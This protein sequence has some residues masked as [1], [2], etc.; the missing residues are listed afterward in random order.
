MNQYNLFLNNSSFFMINLYNHGLTK[1]NFVNKKIM[2]KK[3]GPGSISKDFNMTYV[4]VT[5]LLTK[6]YSI[7]LICKERD[8]GTSRTYY[9]LNDD[10]VNVAERLLNLNKLISIS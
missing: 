10:G 6:F 4:C 3:F 1:D 9:A 2:Y 7:G 5:K 8:T